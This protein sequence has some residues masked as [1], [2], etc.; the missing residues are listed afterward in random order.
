[1]SRKQRALKRKKGICH[2]YSG[3]TPTSKRTQ[4]C[5]ENLDANSKDAFGIRVNGCKRTIAVDADCCTKFAT[6]LD[7]EMERKGKTKV[8]FSGKKKV[9][10]DDEVISRSENG[11]IVGLHDNKNIELVTNDPNGVSCMNRST[12]QIVFVLLPRKCVLNLD[13]ADAIIEAFE[14]VESEHAPGYGQRGKE[15]ELIFEGNM[16]SNFQN[17]GVAANRGGRGLVYKFPKALQGTVHEKSVDKWI[18][19][20][21]NV[22]KKYIPKKLLSSLMNVAKNVGIDPKQLSQRKHK[23]S[24]VARDG[25]DVGAIDCHGKLRMTAIRFLPALAISRNVA[26]SMHTDHDAF[27]CV[28]AVYRRKDVKNHTNR[29]GVQ[30]SRFVYESE[31]LKYFTFGCGISVGMRS[32]DLLIFNPQEPHCISTNS[33]DCDD[34]G[35]ITTSHYLKTNVVG[36]NDNSLYFDE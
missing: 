29:C 18:T 12:G 1:M 7:S 19:Q 17:V 26:L 36:L 6:F 10:R 23:T 21:T 11:C 27:L 24:D 16:K 35:V 28:T 3:N 14:K 30:Q 20:V 9:E 2:A 32:G 25:D 33:D 34:Y 15:R 4:V 31:I 13:G 8:Y 22:V 5:K